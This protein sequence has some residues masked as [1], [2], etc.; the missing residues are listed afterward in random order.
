[1]YLSVRGGGLSGPL[2][3]HMPLPRLLPVVR[4]LLGHVKERHVLDPEA[5]SLRQEQ[6][7]VDAEAS[8]LSLEGVGWGL[9]LKVSAQAAPLNCETSPELGTL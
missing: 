2:S 5:S 9:Y 4:C 6:E 7:V 8:S 3:G 1:M